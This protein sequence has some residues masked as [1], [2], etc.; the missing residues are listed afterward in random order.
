MT[1]PDRMWLMTKDPISAPDAP[2]IIE[3]TF[4]KGLPVL[5]KYR[6]LEVSQPLDLFKKLNEIAGEHGVGRLDIIES[7]FVG[8]KSRGCYETPAGT[9]LLTAHKGKFFFKKTFLKFSLRS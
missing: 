3:L 8:M 2:E 1:P 9:V 7:R 4:E 5:M 6:D